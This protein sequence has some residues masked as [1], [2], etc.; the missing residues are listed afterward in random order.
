VDAT[1]WPPFRYHPDP[2]ATG[3]FQ[4][5]DGPCPYCGVDRGVQYV[6]PIYAIEELDPPCP[7][8]IADGSLAERFDASFTDGS[9]LEGLDPAIVREV[10]TRTPGYSSWQSEHWP[11]HCADAAAYLGPMGYDDLRADPEA[12]AAIRTWLTTDLGWE[13][14]WI[15]EYLP[16]LSRDG[17]STAY[18]FRCLRCGTVLANCDDD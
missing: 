17:G 13:P 1:G 9:T 11:T 16:R 5:S 18:R 10:M 12:T 4:P 8:C 15:D 2:V 7:L 6:G 3:S 14:A